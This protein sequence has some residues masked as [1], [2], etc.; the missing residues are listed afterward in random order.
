MV[1]LNTLFMLTIINEQFI[2]RSISMLYLKPSRRLPFALILFFVC[3]LSIASID[4]LECN[5]KRLLEAR[6]ISDDCL[7]ELMSGDYEDGKI[8]DVQKYMCERASDEDL[9]VYSPKGALWEW[10]Y[11]GSIGQYHAVR[12]VIQGDTWHQHNVT[13]LK[14]VEHGITIVS[15]ILGLKH[16]EILS[17][18]VKGDYILYTQM[19]TG[20]DLFQA[21]TKKYPELKMQIPLI[22]ELKE[23][24]NLPIGCIVY[25][26]KLENQGKLSS[27]QMVSFS[28][29]EGWRPWKG[30]NL[31]EL[32]ESILGLSKTD[33]S[34]W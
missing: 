28:T 16:H 8:F 9:L 30:H 14:F 3:F 5:A 27:E 6:M 34:E 20:Y 23:M 1:E 13:V 11:L 17:A 25:E 33:K 15:R 10:E 22:R 19:T 7:L 29:S 18:E 2:F 26:V 21:M 12:S 32:K 24:E 4:G 31:E